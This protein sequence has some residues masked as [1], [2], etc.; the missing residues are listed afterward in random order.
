[1]IIDDTGATLPADE[2]LR[3]E[4]REIP[5]IQNEDVRLEAPAE[6]VI[7]PV[8]K[9][10]EAKPEP[11]DPRAARMEALA[12]NR[13]VQ[14]TEELAR[15]QDT[16][17]APAAPAAPVVEKPAERMI[18][19][20]VRGQD[21]TLPE[22]EVI[23]RAQK[24]DAADDYL[25]ES[26]Q[27][28]EDA[29]KTVRGEPVVAKPEPAPQPAK[30]DR[31]ASFIEGIQT[32]ADPAE[33]KLLLDQEVTDRA[34]Q[35]ARDI[36][37]GDR[38]AATAQGF[39]SEVDQGYAQLAKDHPTIGSDPITR[40]TVTS[41]VG[42]LEAESIARF[43]SGKAVPDWNFPPAD[44][45]TIASFARAGITAEGVRGY[46]PQDAQALFKDMS[47]KGY[48]L[49]KPAAIIQVA[50]RMVAERFAPATKGADPAPVPKPAPVAVD[51]SQ[52]KTDLQQPTLAAIP[53]SPTSGQFVPKTEAERAQASREEIRSARRAGAKRG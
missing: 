6:P 53:R 39:D 5:Q 8:V 23:A 15:E 30:V 13:R 49:P 9:P 2:T 46:T 38:Q 44:P 33:V 34:K 32:G 25:R 11:V 29:K 1:M 42:G 27:L 52:R 51:R 43:L 17:V 3:T 16:I 47:L 26:R 18:T 20:K 10:E 35:A 31:I 14:A 12:E 19:I 7:A 28:L 50:G 36:I 48:A 22:S 37:N 41:F 24:V 45:E 21:V 4:Q 40:H